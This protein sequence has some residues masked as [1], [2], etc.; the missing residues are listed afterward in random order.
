MSEWVEYKVGQIVSLEYGKSLKNY[1]QGIGKYDVFGT[2]GKIGKTDTYLFDKP[3]V[4]IG[5][6][7]AYREVHYANNPFFVI[8]T[9]F[10]LKTKYD[11]LDIKFLFYWF[12]NKDINLM[13]SGS[14]IPSTSR[15]EVYD[16]DIFL[17]P[18]PEQQA[19]ASVLSSL[20]DKIDLLHRQNETL[21]QLAE[22]LFR[23]WFVEEGQE[24]WEKGFLGDE[25]DFTMG[26]SPPGESF[27]ENGAGIPMFQGNADFE[28]RFP[29]PRIYTTDPKRFAIKHDTLISVRAPVGSQNMAD[30]RCCIGRGLAA[31]RYKFGNCK[32]YA[33]FKLRSMMFE[34]K[35]FNDTGT[36]FG[37]I[38]KSDIENIELLVPPVEIVQRFENEVGVLDDKII[39]NVIQIHKLR[40]TRDILLPKLMSGE[41]RVKTES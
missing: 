34:F 35:Q 37:S 15:D 7:G 32:A 23:Q 40:D 3:S 24:D 17:P 33:Y 4:I 11:F 39:A 14:A 20:D 36:V 28:F 22:T 5:R 38:S 30:E 29:R 41:I 21:E 31:F 16:L 18:L 25:F 26:Q 8:D 27:N 13:D 12:K 6:K 19:I 10:Y 2:N 9:A 1:Q